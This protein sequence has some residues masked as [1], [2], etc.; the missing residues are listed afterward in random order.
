[1][2]RTFE[3]HCDSFTSPFHLYLLFTAVSSFFSTSFLEGRSSSNRR[4]AQK[5]AATCYQEVS[6]PPPLLS[7]PSPCFSHGLKYRRHQP[8]LN[9]SGRKFESRKTGEEG[10]E[11]A[12][13][14]SSTKRQSLRAFQNDRNSL[15]VAGF[16]LMRIVEVYKEIQEQEMNIVSTFVLFFL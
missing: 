2:P 13:G 7:P 5:S 1:M 11:K 6:S 12:S 10:E 15:C 8:R 3:E 4:L 14:V 9:N 16:A